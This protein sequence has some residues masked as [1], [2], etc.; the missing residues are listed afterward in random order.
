MSERQP[1]THSPEQAWFTGRFD[2]FSEHG[3]STARIYLYPRQDTEQ[4]PADI[5][6]TTSDGDHTE[7]VFEG[8]VEFDGDRLKFFEHS[9]GTRAL[10]TLSAVRATGEL[11][12]GGPETNTGLFEPELALRIAQYRE[13]AQRDTSSQDSRTAK[14]QLRA[15]VQKGKP[16]E[17]HVDQ[18]DPHD[19]IMH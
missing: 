17:I 2:A 10:C 16:V 5:R 14:S 19:S 13:Q 6:I 8:E 1:I 12:V 11:F 7:Q 18:H 4:Y 9:A 15:L 3:N